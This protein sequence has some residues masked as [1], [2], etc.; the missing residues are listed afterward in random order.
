LNSL[1]LAGG[2]ALLSL[3]L[4]VPAAYATSRFH[5]RGRSFFLFAVL[6]T[7]M[8]SAALLVMPLYRMAESFNLLNTYT[9]LIIA[10]TAFTLPVVIWLLTGYLRS[11]PASLEEAAMVDGASRLAAL[12]RI[13]LPV[14]APGILVAGV[15]SFIFAWNDLVFALAFVTDSDMYPIT[16]S[17]D[18][19]ASENVVRWDLTMA[20]SVLAVVPIALLF[21]ILQKHLVTAFAAGAVKE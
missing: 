5:F 1:I 16:R 6:V 2:T 19:F 20:A 7:Q 9:A 21:A 4:G 11:V 14:A 17:L 13:V 8:V 3:A 18:R 10:N 15:Y 12:L